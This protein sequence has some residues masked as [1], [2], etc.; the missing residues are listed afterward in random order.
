MAKKSMAFL[1]VAAALAPTVIGQAALSAPYKGFNYLGCRTDSN[2]ART[3]EALGP[4]VSGD[5]TI[6]KC[7]DACSSYSRYI[8]LE[9]GEE[10]SGMH[11]CDFD[12]G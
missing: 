10:V 6:E 9:F 3:L 2:T 8:G 11:C 12:R 4:P 7:I 1:L 5:M